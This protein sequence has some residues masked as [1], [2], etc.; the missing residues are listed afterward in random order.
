[1][2]KLI[3]LISVLVLCLSLACPAFATDTFVPS[4]SNKDHPEIDG[5][6]ELV[7]G[8]GNVIDTLDEGCLII[9]PVSEAET[10]DEIPDDS[11]EILLDV[12]RKLLDG[13]MTLPHEDRLVI[14]DLFDASLICTD[15]HKE[16]LAQDGIRI[17][18]PLSVDISTDAELVV[19]AYVNG[20]W[21]NAYAVS[22]NGDGT[23]TC[24][25]EDVCPIVIAV[26]ESFNSTPSQTGDTSG[27][28]IWAV[29]MA[30]SA[31][32]LVVLMICRRK[33]AR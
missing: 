4:I 10:S 24:T 25:L 5:P 28:V 33:S 14:R 2:K 3:S 11:R 7:D 27:I 22:N 26:P 16:R 6:I 32:A 13:S 19:M 21:V 12:Y 30:V 29:V 23:I 31:A 9:T 17:R 1:M 18:I 15:G 8:D 20:Q